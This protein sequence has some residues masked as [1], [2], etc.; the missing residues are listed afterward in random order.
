MDVVPI[1]GWLAS[2][3]ALVLVVMLHLKV[4]P[5]FLLLMARGSHAAPL[6]VV[7]EF[8]KIP[9]MT[10]VISTT[11]PT[12]DIMAEWIKH[13]SHA[14]VSAGRSSASRRFPA[15]RTFD[16]FLSDFCIYLQ[17]KCKKNAL[18]IS[19]CWK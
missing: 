8:A 11:Q 12:A 1:L 4:R 18:P 19:L 14:P 5:L 16:T 17:D 6:A 3:A 9:P 15:S 13:V 2:G 7:Q 10:T